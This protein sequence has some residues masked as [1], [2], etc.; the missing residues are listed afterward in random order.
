MN[1]QHEG[2]I[3]EGKDPNIKFRIEALIRKPRGC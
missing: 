1:P 3:K 2:L